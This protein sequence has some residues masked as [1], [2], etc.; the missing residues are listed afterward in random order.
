VIEALRAI[1]ALALVLGLI[2]ALWRLGRFLAQRRAT[3]EGQ[4]LR[5]VATRYLEPRKALLLVEVEGRRLLLA[6]GPQGIQLLERLENVER[7]A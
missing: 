7:G 2:L 5:V 3:P 4:R 1:A 6:L